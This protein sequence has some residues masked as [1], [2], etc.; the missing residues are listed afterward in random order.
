M[1]KIKL[2]KSSEGVERY[3]A[4]FSPIYLTIIGTIVE[5]T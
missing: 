3:A 2:D 5:Q 4:L 1:G